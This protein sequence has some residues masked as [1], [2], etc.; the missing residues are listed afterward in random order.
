MILSKKQRFILFLAFVFFV[1]SL[2]YSVASAERG[3]II[4]EF[5]TGVAGQ[6]ADRFEVTFDCSLIN[7]TLGGVYVEMRQFDV[8]GDEVEVFFDG[9]SLGATTTTSSY[10][11]YHFDLPNSVDCSSGSK[12]LRYE[13][14]LGDRFQVLRDSANDPSIIS[15]V[16]TYNNGVLGFNNTTNGFNVGL[17]DYFAAEP[18][19]S[20]LTPP[21]YFLTLPSIT[22]CSGTSTS[23][24]CT[25]EYSTTTSPYPDYTKHFDILN[26]LLGVSFFMVSVIFFRHLAL[27]FL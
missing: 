19:S 16:Q 14:G 2:L 18:T 12:I 5:S 17:Y 21:Q 22:T 7:D 13:A 9:V 3:D 24:V 8:V 4:Y 6:L 26:I 27:K 1:N 15:L 20:V 25:F 23:S 11:K 10:Q